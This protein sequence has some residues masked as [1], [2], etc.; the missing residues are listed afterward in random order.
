MN[1]EELNRLSNKIIGIAIIVHKKLGPG[2][3]EKIYE[4]AL[5]HEL[6]KNNISCVIQVPVK[7][8]YDDISIG[9]QRI[10]I[11]VKDEIILELKSVSDI[12]NCHRAQLIS[13]LKATNKKL[14]LILNFAKVKLEIKR[15]V[16][17]F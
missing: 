8:K 6:K 2:F 16:N 1:K 7:I 14:G 10:D 4:R 17:N 15:I 12:H 13:Y 11:I 9:G 5:L 3:V